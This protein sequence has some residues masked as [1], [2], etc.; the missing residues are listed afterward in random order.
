MT[1]MLALIKTFS[2]AAALFSHSVWLPT[3]GLPLGTDCLVPAL[4]PTQVLLASVT[5]GLLQGTKLCP[6][7]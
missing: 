1:Q 7:S 6:H 5:V 2:A 3:R 4:V